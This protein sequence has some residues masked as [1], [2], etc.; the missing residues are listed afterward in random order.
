MTTAPI[1]AV[2]STTP[3][4]RGAGTLFALALPL[5]FVSGAA[6]LVY[7]V[8]W[9]RRALL[10]VGSTSAASAVVL[11]AFLGGLGLGGRLG[12]PLADRVRR[13][14]VLYGALECLAA[15]WAAAFPW[16]LS[17]L[18]T[19]YVGIAGP[20][21]P[22]V[23]WALR[24]VVAAIAVV[25]GALALGATF[26]ALLSAV[27]RRGAKP[28]PAAAWIYGVNTAGAVAGALWCGFTGIFELG[29]IGAI[30]AAAI[31]A[32]AAGVLAILAGLRAATRP[33]ASP[34][35]PAFGAGAGAFP[36]GALAAAFLGGLVGLGLE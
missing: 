20:V 34:P 1:P 17:G 9:T 11:A 23:R 18:E 5:A 16:T 14:L 35:A 2:P 33:D 22:T 25:P 6:A 12:G 8:A 10:V 21:A 19:A 27:A 7:E 3:G 24:L 36:R 29:V 31:V 28:G 15:A 26:P 32:A 13:P 4:A 30:R